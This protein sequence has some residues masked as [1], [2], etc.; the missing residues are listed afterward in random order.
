M[1]QI[2]HLSSR[3]LDI[4]DFFAETSDVFR[5][6]EKVIGENTYKPISQIFDNQAFP[7][8]NIIDS[9]YYP[10]AI[11]KAVTA[12]SKIPSY[13]IELALAGYKK[14][15]LQVKVVDHKLIVS[16]KDKSEEA[17]PEVNYYVKGITSKDFD[18]YFPLTRNAE[19]KEVKME[20]G[21]LSIRVDLKIEK[22]DT[23]LLEIK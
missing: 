13:T 6:F 17:K 12:E 4:N 16:T 18:W 2:L 19:V 3:P 22:P 15:D 23:T 1:K 9:S 7:R 21:I 14:D 11:D 20:D 5:M 8:M 10:E